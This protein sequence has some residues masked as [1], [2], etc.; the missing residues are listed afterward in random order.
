ML[1]DEDV[2]MACGE[3]GGL[4]FGVIGVSAKGAS[5]QIAC[6]PS[7]STTTSPRPLLLYSHQLQASIR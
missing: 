4:Y 1:W 5:G 6:S 3:V 7:S 2:F